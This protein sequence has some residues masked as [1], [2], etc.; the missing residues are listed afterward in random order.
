MG[1]YGSGRRSDKP[2]IEECNSID[3]NQLN[4]SGCL[5]NG[6]SGTITWSRNGVKTSSIIMRASTESLHL[7]YCTKEYGTV[8]PVT[9]HRT[10][11]LPFWRFKGIL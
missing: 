7:S 4:R 10:P 11:T 8:Y 9:S 2:K 3:A 1:G 5:K 6:W